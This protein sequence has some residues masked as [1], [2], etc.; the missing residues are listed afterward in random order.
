M[1][2]LIE[3]EIDNLMTPVDH[4]EWEANPEA[5]TAEVRK[6]RLELRLDEHDT[7]EAAQGHLDRVQA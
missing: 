3:V 4:D 2:R 5:V 7:T 6:N 1:E